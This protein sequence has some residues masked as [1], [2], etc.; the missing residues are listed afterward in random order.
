MRFLA[1][2]TLLSSTLFGA[3]EFNRDVRPIL[4]DKCYS[5]HGADAVP[6]KIPLRLDSEAA[7]KADLGGRRA[8]VDGDPAASLLIRRI[9]SENK[10]QRGCRSVDSGLELTD[11]EIDTLRQWV[12]QG[13]KW[14]KHWSFIPRSV[15]HC[16]PS[17]KDGWARNPID[18]FV[19]QKLETQGLSLLP[20]DTPGEPSAPR[21][22]R[23]PG[24]AAY[25]AEMGAFLKDKSPDAYE[26]AVDRLLASPRYGERMAG[27]AGRRPLRGHTGY[28][29]DAERYHVALAGLGDRCL[30]PQHAVRPVHARTDRRRP[31]AQRHPRQKIATGFNRNHRNNDRRWNH[32]RRV[33]PSSTWS[34]AWRR[35]PPLAGRDARLRAVPQPQVR[36]DH[37]KRV[38][39]GV[40]RTSITCP[41]SAGQ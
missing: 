20:E 18:L 9:T 29:Y 11:G 19:L 10:A 16:L 35:P 24:P 14:Q 26:K 15:P 31:A 30:Q 33:S 8:I 23:S 25:V 39:S 12:A 2:G 13:A 22:P 5:C 3:V 36:P 7:A 34:I 4:A 21:Y 37:A 27:L 41:S 38:L 40:Y 1:L 28:Q 32:P 6:K 17:R